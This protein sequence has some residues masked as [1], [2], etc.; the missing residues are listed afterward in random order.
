[1]GK[2][3]SEALNDGEISRAERTGL[4]KIVDELETDLS[5]A[6]KKAVREFLQLGDTF[7]GNLASQLFGVSEADADR[8]EK[9]GASRAPPTSSPTRARTTTACASP[10]PPAWT[11]CS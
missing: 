8:L 6:A 1:M 11:S 10:A 2:V 9:A 7:D 3:L 5:L 4:N